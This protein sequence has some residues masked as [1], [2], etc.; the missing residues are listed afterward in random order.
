MPAL[1]LPVAI[2][3]FVLLEPLSEGEVTSVYLGVHG[4][5]IGAQHFCAIKVMNLGNTGLEDNADRFMRE[6]RTVVNLSHRNICHVF[7]VGQ[8]ENLL[9]VAMEYIQGQTLLSVLRRLEQH[10]DCL[11]PA[12]AVY[13]IREVLDALDYAHRFKDPQT[14]L[15]DPIVHSDVTPLN[16]LVSYAGEPKVIDFSAARTV[17][18]I[19][20]AADHA[21]SGDPCYISPEQASGGKVDGRAD[22]YSAAVVLSELLLGRRYHQD[23]SIADQLRGTISKDYRPQGFDALEPNL[24]AI[25]DRALSIDPDERFE[26]CAAFA[27]ALAEYQLEYRHHVHAGVLRDK[28]EELFEAE[29]RRLRDSLRVLSRQVDRILPV[30][31]SA[32]KPQARNVN[33]TLEVKFRISSDTGTESQSQDPAST[34]STSD[35]GLS[36]SSDVLFEEAT[37]QAP[38][39]VL[40]LVHSPQSTIRDAAPSIPS[41]NNSAT[42]G[43]SDLEIDV[44][45]VE[46]P[47]RKSS[48]AFEEDTIVDP[49]KLVADDSE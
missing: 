46:P 42:D 4:T 23:V 17:H 28:M 29:K 9:F 45:D 34:A 20:D 24:R 16:I 38:P 3:D 36:R 48:G 49:R 37:V 21:Y 26:S 33:E 5:M 2:S 19:P 35:A 25:L 43:L 14:H 40:D 10:S 44:A 27:D 41:T 30:A 47:S 7:E 15:P 22:L 8:A 12:L 31:R 11:E 39:A 32:G 1:R 13:V 6:A 18:T